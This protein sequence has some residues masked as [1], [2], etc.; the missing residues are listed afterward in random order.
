MTYMPAQPSAH[1]ET[2]SDSES[3]DEDDEENLDHQAAYH[4][5]DE[6]P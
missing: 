3:D 5:E 2:S 1:G 4:S 6:S